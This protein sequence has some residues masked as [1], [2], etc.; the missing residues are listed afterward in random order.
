MIVRTG[1][2]AVQEAVRRLNVAGHVVKRA[3]DRP[4]RYYVDDGPEMTAMQLVNFAARVKDDFEEQMTPDQS[5]PLPFGAL[6]VI[7]LVIGIV[8]T[9]LIMML[10]RG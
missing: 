4:E 2:R 3:V 5:Y 9:P 6:L 7:V 1:E 8:G 10:Y